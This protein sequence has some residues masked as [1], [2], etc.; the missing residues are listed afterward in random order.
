MSD[1]NVQIRLRRIERKQI[2]DRGIAIAAL[3][4]SMVV[5]AWTF[6]NSNVQLALTRKTEERQAWSELLMRFDDE[7][8]WR[9]KKTLRSFAEQ[10]KRMP[11]AMQE[12]T[13][14]EGLLTK[15]STKCLALYV[16]ATNVL[17]PGTADDCPPKGMRAEDKEKYYSEVDRARRT[18]KNFHENVM[19]LAKQDSITEPVRQRFVRAATVEFLTNVW[20][21]VEKGQ[22]RVVDKDAD[23]KDKNA[24]SVRDW[25]AERVKSAEE[26]KDR[27]PELV[28]ETSYY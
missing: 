3:V 6:W 28:P 8:M 24:Q 27:K 18:V 23:T 14:S 20:L 9:A 26:P 7:Q 15:I 12:K 1:I 10:I 4:T 17:G 25:Y 5:G 16:Y 22:N 21:P 11:E 2:F 19:M 13:G